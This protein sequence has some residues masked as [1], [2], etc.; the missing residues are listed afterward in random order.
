M[1]YLIKFTKSLLLGL[2][3]FTL[4]TQFFYFIFQNSNVGY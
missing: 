3:N 2:F 1:T 4:G